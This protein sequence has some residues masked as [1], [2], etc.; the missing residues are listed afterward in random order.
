MVILLLPAQFYVPDSTY[1]AAQ[2]Q[3]FMFPTDIMDLVA[4]PL[5][6]TQYSS[7]RLHCEH[8]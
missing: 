4:P 8:D 6:N 2:E 5:Q 3:I 1:P 7:Y